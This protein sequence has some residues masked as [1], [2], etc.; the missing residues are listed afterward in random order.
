[1]ALSQGFLLIFLSPVAMFAVQRPRRIGA[2]T[3]TLC[4][5]VKPHVRRAYRVI[6]GLC[7]ALF[8]TIQFFNE[9]SKS[10]W[11]IGVIL[12]GISNLLRK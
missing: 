10:M 11:I 6:P 3:S 9:E 4:P 7:G 5:F 8:R 12:G 2:V 1:M